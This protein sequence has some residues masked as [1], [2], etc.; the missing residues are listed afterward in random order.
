MDRNERHS[1]FYGLIL[2][3][4]CGMADE[5]QQR[6]LYEMIES[7]P[8]LRDEYVNYTLTYTLLHRRSGSSMFVE[9]EKNPALDYELWRNLA[10]YEKNAPVVE[11]PKEKPKRELIQKVEYAPRP[12]TKV[13]KLNIFILVLNS[14]AM[15]FL[16]LFIILAPARHGAE[17]ATLADCIDAEWR[18][19]SCPMEK[20]VRLST[21]CDKFVLEDG[22]AELLFDNNTK[23]VIEAPADFQI[24]SENQID[25][26]YGR[27]YATVPAE[28]IGFA[29]STPTSRIVDLGTEFGIEADT[30]GDVYLHVVKGK[31][32]LL[33]GTRSKSNPQEVTQ[34]QAKKV[35]G[36]TLAV[37]D[38]PCQADLFVSDID[39]E[40]PVNRRKVTNIRFGDIVI[41]Y[42]SVGQESLIYPQGRVNRKL[43]TYFRKDKNPVSL[44]VGD[45]LTA[46]ID[47][48]PKGNIYD[49][50]VRGL[51]FGLFT[52]PTDKHILTYSDDDRGGKGQAWTDASGYGVEIALSSGPQS[53][54]PPRVGKRTDL[55]NQSLFG[56]DDAWTFSD[57]D[58]DIVSAVDTRYT[59]KL[60]LS[61]IAENRM[62]ITFTIS[63]ADRVISTH[64]IMDDPLGTGR[65]GSEPIYTDFD[66]L[67][68]RLSSADSTADTIEFHGFKIEYSAGTP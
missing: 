10:D 35:S 65:F 40:K 56:D 39:S 63:D 52:D 50:S 66:Q 64:T 41:G 47:F 26:A 67:F 36:S 2:S 43:W 8:G 6:Q 57:G 29:V 38:I 51:R 58:V 18:Q 1:D 22:L 23:V 44:N 49:N 7:D 45:S 11:I 12:K 4:L 15:L 34:G 9:D 33:T 24:R 59:L 46:V 32:S 19:N 61:R 42:A 28:A 31:T 55:T 20:G 62:Q 21:G 37:T 27:I 60:I 16:V 53:L 48:T 13:S 25:L 14:A 5:Q 3:V 30:F 68:F 54:S 17:V